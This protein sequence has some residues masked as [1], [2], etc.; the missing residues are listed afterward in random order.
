MRKRNRSQIILEA[1]II[2]C[3]IIVFFMLIFYTVVH[4]LNK[5]MVSEYQGYMSERI[6]V[7][8]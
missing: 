7:S 6:A 3:V 1:A 4:P 8:E 2:F 5:M